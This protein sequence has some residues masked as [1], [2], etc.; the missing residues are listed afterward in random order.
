M[1]FSVLVIFTLIVLIKYSVQDNSQHKHRKKNRKPMAAKNKF[2]IVRP[3]E[4]LKSSKLP[5]SLFT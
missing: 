4:V 5:R 3:V 2:L 1:L